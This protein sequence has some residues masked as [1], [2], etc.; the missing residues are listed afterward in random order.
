MDSK[1][2]REGW[3]EGRRDGKEGI[4]ERTEGKEGT[5]GERWRGR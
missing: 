2:Q 1:E 5:E 3:K 4:I